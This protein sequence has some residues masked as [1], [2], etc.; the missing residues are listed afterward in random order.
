MEW[1]RKENMRISM[2]HAFLPPRN[3]GLSFKIIV[4]TK[5]G[6][7]RNFSMKLTIV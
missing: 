5:E 7:V 1:K 2:L 4:L 6:Q 3:N